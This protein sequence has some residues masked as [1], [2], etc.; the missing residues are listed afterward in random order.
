M[1]TLRDQ[2][3]EFKGFIVGLIM[4]LIGCVLC[5]FI[6]PNILEGCHKACGKLLEGNN[7]NNKPEKKKHKEKV[8]YGF[9]I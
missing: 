6:G 8:K 1:R 2:L 5:T 4:G 3:F 7:D 9:H